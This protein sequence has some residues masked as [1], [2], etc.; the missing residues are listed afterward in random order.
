[1]KTPPHLAGLIGAIT[2]AEEACRGTDFEWLIRKDRGG[3][4]AN[5]ANTHAEITFPTHAKT[6][7][8]AL[9]QSV[10]Q[11]NLRMKDK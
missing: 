11:F 7:G 3:Y 10:M 1:M 4:L 6:P 2:A 9:A 8:G 5:I